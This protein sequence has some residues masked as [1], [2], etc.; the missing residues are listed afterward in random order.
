MDA[1]RQ[2]FNGSVDDQIESLMR[3]HKSLSGKSNKR[4]RQKINEKVAR[5]LE[6]QRG[7]AADGNESDSATS[8]SGSDSGSPTQSPAHNLREFL[9]SFGPPPAMAAAAGR[10]RSGTRRRHGTPPASPP[11]PQAWGVQ[12]NESDQPLP[13]PFTYGLSIDIDAIYT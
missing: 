7:Q 10:S 8:T 1:L 5:L 12:R 13:G 2:P 6:A 3:L 11:Q 4:A 9:P